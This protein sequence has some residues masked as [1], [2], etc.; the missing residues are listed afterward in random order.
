M[1][2]TPPLQHAEVAPP[3]TIARRPRGW[4]RAEMPATAAFID[5]A[6]RAFFAT[7]EASAELDAQILRAMRGEPG[8]FHAVEAGREIGTPFDPPSASFTYVEPD[9]WERR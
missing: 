4:L 8:L 7:P 9:R 3:A 1:S 5:A 2:A 6:R